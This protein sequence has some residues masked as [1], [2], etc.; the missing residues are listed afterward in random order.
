M[1]RSYNAALVYELFSNYMKIIFDILLPRLYCMTRIK[2]Y[3][4]K[5]ILAGCR[6]YY[7]KSKIRKGNIDSSFFSFSLLLNLSRLKH[8]S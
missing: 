7:S 3:L 8:P 6:H 4:K 1:K 5:C 2:H